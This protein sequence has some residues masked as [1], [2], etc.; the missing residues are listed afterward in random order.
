MTCKNDGAAVG[1]C[2]AQHHIADGLRARRPGQL[3]SQVL[4]C[5]AVKCGVLQCVVLCVQRPGLKFAKISLI[6]IVYGA[7]SSKLTFENLCYIA[8]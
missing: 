6:V 5:V 7:F 8:S 4:Q 3:E 2:V 1:A